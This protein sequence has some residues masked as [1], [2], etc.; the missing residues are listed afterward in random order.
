MQ[1]LISI[2][3][4]ASLF[5]IFTGCSTHNSPVMA[6]FPPHQG[7]VFITEQSLPSSV[8][9]ELISTIEVEKK[10]YGSSTNAITPLAERARELGANAVIQLK[11]WFA[12]S[13]FSW[14]APHAAGQAVKVKNINSLESNGIKGTWN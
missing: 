6:V 3:L 11:T 1:K 4:V 7:R 5:T 2:F 13:G 10:W 14:A 9:F 8:E 12:P